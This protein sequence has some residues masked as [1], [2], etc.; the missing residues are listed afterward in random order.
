ME[1]KSSKHATT[2]K[3]DKNICGYNENHTCNILKKNHLLLHLMK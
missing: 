3:G 1:F 2:I